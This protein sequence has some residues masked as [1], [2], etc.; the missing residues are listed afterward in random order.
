VR[1]L[2]RTPKAFKVIMVDINRVC[3]VVDEECECPANIENC[4][5]EEINLRTK[6]FACGLY[7]CKKCSKVIKWY[8]FGRR[9]I[10]NNCVHDHKRKPGI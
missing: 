7:V 9:R 3:C 5:I 1:I 8:N 2:I 4:L 10:C 6:C